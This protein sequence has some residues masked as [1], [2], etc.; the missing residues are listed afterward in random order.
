[1][2]A[3]RRSA[4]VVVASLLCVAGSRLLVHAGDDMGLEWKA[5]DKKSGA[6]YQV[7][8][9]NTSQVMKVMQMDVKQEQKQT[10]YIKWEPADLDGK[11]NWVVTQKII[12]VKMDIDIGG[13]KISYDSTDDKAPKNPMSDF[14]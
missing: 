1:M 7:L 10:F 5:F 6:F 9:T 13:N 14:F 2:I 11:G 4:F 8:T 3:W 12:G